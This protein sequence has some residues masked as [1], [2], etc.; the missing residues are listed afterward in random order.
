[1]S[2]LEAELTPLFLVIASGVGIALVARTGVEPSIGVVG[3]TV[4]T[5][6]PSTAAAATA[7]VVA[8]S[9]AATTV[10]G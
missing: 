1:V 5:P 4:S 9:S 7:V 3:A 8:A 6:T 2:W 10:V